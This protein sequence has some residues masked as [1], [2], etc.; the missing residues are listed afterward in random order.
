[1]TASEVGSFFSFLDFRRE[2]LPPD[3]PAQR[4]W[5]GHLVESTGRLATEVFK[6]AGL[7][8]QM[9]VLE[10]ASRESG[11]QHRSIGMRL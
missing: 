5:V 6:Q 7:D 10:S 8:Q 11:E 3:Q 2:S 9:E 4:F 1:M